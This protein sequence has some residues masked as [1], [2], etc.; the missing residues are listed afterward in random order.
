MFDLSHYCLRQYF[1]LREAGY[2][3]AGIDP[4]AVPHHIVGEEVFNS[5]S[6]AASETLH[7]LWVLDGR[8]VHPDT[9][10][11]LLRPRELDHED[12]YTPPIEF[13]RTYVERFR[14]ALADDPDALVYRAEAIANWFDHNG[15][16]FKPKFNFRLGS[17]PEPQS[18]QD[19][20]ISRRE[21][22]TYLN[23]IGALLELVLTPRDG[24]NSQTAV[25]NE[26][27][28]NYGEKPGISK[29]SLTLKFA[30]AKRS[31]NDS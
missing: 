13:G 14:K 29:S 2:L 11:K 8:A 23:I 10:C 15:R 24:R 16:N 25:I 26:L 3:A 28:E 20:P 5:L 4:A 9:E 1:T 18:T 22:R 30:D 21:E 12:E 17:S 31:L 19:R 7:E 6:Q 27:V